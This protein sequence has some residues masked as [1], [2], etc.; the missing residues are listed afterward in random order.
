M[1]C[2]IGRNDGTARFLAWFWSR[3]ASP[4]WRWTQRERTNLLE[5][6]LRQRT[7]SALAAA[8]RRS[9]RQAYRETSTWARHPDLIA[10]AYRRLFPTPYRH[11]RGPYVKHG[12]TEYLMECKKVV[13]CYLH[14][15]GF[16][17][18]NKWIRYI[19]NAL[20]LRS[21]SRS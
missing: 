20:T 6:G 15:L 10:R 4:G 1:G 12:R 11:R 8:K 7:Y 5:F 14:P 18:A 17:T 2:V 9:A 21:W 3:R 13:R 19:A 16:S